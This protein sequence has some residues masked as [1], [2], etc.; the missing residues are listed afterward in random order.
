MPASIQAGQDVS[1]NKEENLAYI[2]ML[3]GFAIIGVLLVHSTIGME[4]AGLGALPFHLE[5]LLR[6][7]KHGVD[8]FFAVS[9]FTL[10]RSM[11]N[12]ISVEH[13]AMRKY[14]LRRFF[15]IA[16]AYYVVLVV[17]FVFYG[18]G[19]TGYVDPLDA[20]LSELDLIAHLLFLNGFSPYFTNDF[21]GVEWSISTEF[22]FYVLLPFIFIW[23]NKA[24]SK[25]QAIRRAAF[26]Y[27]VGIGLYWV[28]FFKVDFSSLGGGFAA[29]ISPN[30]LYFFITSHLHVFIAGVVAWL[31]LLKAAESR[32]KIRSSILLVGLA[33]T[34]V[35]AIAGA[36]LEWLWWGDARVRWSCLV[37]WGVLSSLL[38]YL[39][40]MLKPPCIFGLSHFGKMSFSLYLVHFPIL[41]WLRDFVKVWAMSAVPGV[42]FIIYVFFGLGLSYFLALLLYKFVEQPGMKLGKVLINRF[43]AR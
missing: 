28:T 15:R 3:R 38:I 10:M 27:F 25:S 14:F 42:N 31:V 6:A 41:Y 43:P 21:L 35:L 11:H 23:L 39:L 17:V 36:Y 26:L 40:G 34:V 29:P 24:T 32:Q 7:G 4:V 13:M 8:L 37:F 1:I 2:D 30:W 9:A 22:L 12:R 19:I 5:W 20:T 33:L 18:K 16:P